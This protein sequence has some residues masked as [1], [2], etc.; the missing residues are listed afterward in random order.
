M[1][2]VILTKLQAIAATNSLTRFYPAAA[3][4]ALAQRL[5]AT[6]DF[7]ALAQRWDM[8]TELAL[9]L[10]ALS[11]YDVVILADGRVIHDAAGNAGQ[12]AFFE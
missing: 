5:E 9:D 3:L 2:G 4:A 12:G 11:L 1:Q 10:A 6:V 7:R 8:P